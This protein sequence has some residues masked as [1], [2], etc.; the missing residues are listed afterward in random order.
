MKTDR[1]DDVL[2]DWAGERPDLSSA[3][4]GIVLRIQTLDKV[5]AEHVSAPLKALD[6]AWWEYDVLSVLRRQGAPFQMPATEIAESAM[7]SASAM[8]NRIDR[9]ED[10]QLVR[11]VVDDADRRRV[12]VQLSRKGRALVDRATDSRFASADA[13]LHDLSDAQRNQL[14][15]LL[16]KLT[17]SHTK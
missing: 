15:R 6:L 13:A 9:L 14:D 12:L 4:M 10:R 1:I 8:T 16:R 3:A 7:L 17:L 11:R 5:L 2:A